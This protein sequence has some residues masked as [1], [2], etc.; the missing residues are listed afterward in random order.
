LIKAKFIGAD[1]SMGFRNGK[2]YWVSV[3]EKNGMIWVKTFFGCPCPY[4][5]IKSLQRNWDIDKDIIK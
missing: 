4:A 1:G 2:S 5:G 3:K